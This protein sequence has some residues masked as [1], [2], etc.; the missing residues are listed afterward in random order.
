MGKNGWLSLILL[1]PVI[2]LFYLWRVVHGV[3]ENA[4][5]SGKLVRLDQEQAKD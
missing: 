2:N 3:W 4:D 5:E 1:I